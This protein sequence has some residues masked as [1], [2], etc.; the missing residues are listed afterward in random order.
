MAI[1]KTIATYEYPES[2]TYNGPSHRAEFNFRSL[3]GTKLIVKWLLEDLIVYK[4]KMTDVTPL[5]A[6][7][8][9]KEIKLG[10]L[11][12]VTDDYILILYFH[13]SPA[14]A[15]IILAIATAIAAAG[16]LVLSWNSTPDTWRAISQVPANLAKIPA[17]FAEIPKQT[18]TLVLSLAALFLSYNFIKNRKKEV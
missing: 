9:H 10:Y 18:S 17:K 3:K 11:D 7:L 8:K 15:S 14:V 13:D 6:V 5:R 2:K 12:Y 16:F 4:S 1:Y